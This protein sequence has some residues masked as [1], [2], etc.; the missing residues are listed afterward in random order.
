M[1]ARIRNRKNNEWETPAEGFDWEHVSI[2]VLMDIRAE[3]VKLNQMLSCYRFQRMSN[4]INRIDK[5]LLKHGLKLR[6]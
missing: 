3:L 2:E 5:R 6:D 4:D 1:M